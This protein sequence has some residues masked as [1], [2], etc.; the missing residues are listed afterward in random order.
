MSNEICDSWDSKCD[1]GNPVLRDHCHRS[2]QAV[3]LRDHWVKN[4]VVFLDKTT[5]VQRPY[6]PGRRSYM[7]MY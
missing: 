3:V 5:C 2:T 1:T 7:Y 6:I 4:Q